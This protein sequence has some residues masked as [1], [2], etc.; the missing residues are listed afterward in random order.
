MCS[1]FYVNALH[2]FS[3]LLSSIMFGEDTN[4]SFSQCNI[5]VLFE[6]TNEE[7]TNVTNWFNTNKIFLNV[8]KNKYFSFH[9]TS[10]KDNIPLRLPNI[11]MNG[12]SIEREPSVKFLQV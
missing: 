3:T 11:K 5:N 6:K 9:K 8:I 7:L 2:H 4:L 12:L 1:V 10:K